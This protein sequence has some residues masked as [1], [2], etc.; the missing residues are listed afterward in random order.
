MQK[1]SS[2]REIDELD[3]VG[4]A[5]GRRNQNTEGIEGIEG[6]RT[7]DKENLSIP[8]DTLIYDYTYAWF[9]LSL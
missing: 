1:R 8:L 5:S 2:V 3:R 9:L 4:R 6:V 7:Y